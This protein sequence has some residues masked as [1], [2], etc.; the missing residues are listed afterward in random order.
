MRRAA[1]ET[2]WWW[3]KSEGDFE[4]GGGSWRDREGWKACVEDLMVAMLDVRYRH[5][6][7]IE[8]TFARL[9]QTL[10]SNPWN[11]ALESPHFSLVHPGHLSII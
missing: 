1:G 4:R 5:D 2:S 3:N 9:L 11:H 8:S 6:V 10:P 7:I